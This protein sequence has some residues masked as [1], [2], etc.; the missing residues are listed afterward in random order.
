MKVLLGFCAVAFV[1]LLIILFLAGSHGFKDA[2]LHKAGDLSREVKAWKME[3]RPEAYGFTNA[4]Q[5]CY[6]YRTNIV[7]RSSVYHSIMRL[8]SSL[9]R[10]KGYLLATDQQELFWIESSG[11]VQKLDW[12]PK[13]LRWHVVPSR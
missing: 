13:E 9:F 5:A 6:I 11:P 3:S 7:F 10:S 1:L 8:D 2:K 4:L 12:D